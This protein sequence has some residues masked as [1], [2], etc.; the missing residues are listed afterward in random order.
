MTET[1]GVYLRSGHDE[2]RVGS[3]VRDRRDMIR[4]ITD[5]SYIEL[6][7]D[8]PVLSSSMLFVGD[9][10]RTVGHLKS[11]R[12]TQPGR[13]LPPW[14]GNLLPE[15]ALRDM[16]SRGLPSGRTSDFDILRYLGE[17]L[18]GGVIVRSEDGVELDGLVTP[19]TEVATESGTIKFSLA[20][21][22]LKMSML[23]QDER[24]TFPATGTNGDIIA[25]LPST[26]YAF[27]PEVEFTC[28][29]LAE[30]AG[31]VMPHCELVPAA[32]VSGIR[33]EALSG[34]DYVLA[35]TRFD[36]TADGGRV[37]IEDFC[38]VMEVP[39]ERKYTAANEETVMNI[40]KR[41]GGGTRG[42]LEIARRLAVNILMGNGDAHL[43]NHSLIYSDPRV[44]GISPAYDLVATFLYDGSD[45]LALKFRNTN[46]SAI[47]GMAR[48]ARAAEL[49]G[50]TENVVRKF[51]T[52]TVEQAADTWPALIGDLPMP[53][54]FAKK[55][56][57]RAQRLQLSG[58]LNVS[59]AP[60][61]A[62][63]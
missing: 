29:K 63:D 44:G 46:N 18:P 57:D 58:E 47:V 53:A 37:H 31:V 15:G 32:S 39:K 1:L 20:G 21:V 41:L 50:I 19:S 22:Q 40:A 13:D 30:A 8:R 35:V 60:G 24:L 36:R 38:Q 4:F 7:E 11:G 6:G 55:L 61:A 23:K 28:M 2:T 43:K 17:D 56:V 52:H 48:F 26:R 42:F 3:L 33:A 34:G 12:F 25:K 5:A 10:E 49:C 54:D 16:V 27:L 14:F 9:E 45:D 62:A 59:F 51:V